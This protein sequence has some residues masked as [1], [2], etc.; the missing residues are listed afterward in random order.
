MNQPYPRSIFGRTEYIISTPAPNQSVS[1]TKRTSKT[2]RK[3]VRPRCA[4]GGSASAKSDPKRDQLRSFPAARQIATVCQKGGAELFRSQCCGGIFTAKLCF[5]PVKGRV[6][7]RA[8]RGFFCSG[9]FLCRGGKR[10]VLGLRRFVCRSG[11][12]HSGSACFRNGSVLPAEKAPDR[13]CCPEA[14]GTACEIHFSTR[15]VPALCFRSYSGRADET[16]FPYFSY[17][18]AEGPLGRYCGDLCDP[19]VCC[20]LTSSI[21]NTHAAG[22]QRLARRFFKAVFL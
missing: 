21:P 19:F 6:G 4:L 15:P 18:A 8:S 11:I 1:N 17:T 14:G 12:L 9:G 16:V 20:H 22:R 5:C 3:A 2:I 10:P 7:G 13:G